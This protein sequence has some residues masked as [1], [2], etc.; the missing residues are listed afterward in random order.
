[1]FSSTLSPETAEPP[2]PDPSQ[3]RRE[4]LVRM[5]Q[6]LADGGL[7]AALALSQRVTR[8]ALS[9]GS[10]QIV[11]ADIAA[12]A[13]ALDRVGRFVRR[14]VALEEALADGALAA[15]LKAREDRAAQA[16]AR[17]ER[18]AQRRNTVATGMLG[19]IDDSHVRPVCEIE[20]LLDDLHDAL[21]LE[22]DETFADEG[23]IGAILWRL[24]RQLNLAVDLAAWENEDW[25]AEEI[26]ERPPDSPFTA[27]RVTRRAPDTPIWSERP[28]EAP[29]LS[30][31]G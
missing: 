11:V 22:P 29:E 25:A 30:A 17:R 28:R 10:D 3:E 19:L 9:E 12:T 5:M 2:T 26:V 4:Q 24:C 16:A 1:M 23:P 31:S 18:V 14:A 13:L 6:A 21:D 20:R 15:K 27:Y 7:E 8:L